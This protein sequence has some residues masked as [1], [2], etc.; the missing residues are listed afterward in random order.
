MSRKFEAINLM[1]LYAQGSTNGWNDF[2]RECSVSQD[3]N[4][5][6]KVKYQIQAGMDDLAKAKLN[7]PDIDVWFLRLVRSIEIEAKRIIKM[8]HPMPGDNPLIAKKFEKSHLDV[9][10]S[11]DR[12]LAKFL[13]DSSY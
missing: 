2:L 8:R 4:R 5:L 11:R 10:R 6:A 3:I 13:K 7:T 1:K 12:E 9:K